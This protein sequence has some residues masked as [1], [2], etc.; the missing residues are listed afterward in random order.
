MGLLHLPAPGFSSCWPKEFSP[1][2]LNPV[3]ANPSTQ[4]GHPQGGA[5]VTAAGKQAIRKET[6]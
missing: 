5:L 2:S 1:E 4:S 3:K 6:H